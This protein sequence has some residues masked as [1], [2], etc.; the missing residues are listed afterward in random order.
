M[1]TKMN[2]LAGLLILAGTIVNAQSKTSFGLRGGVNF[3]NITGK[4][5]DGDKLDGKL[6]T[7][8]NLGVNAEIPIGIDFYIQ[9]GVLYTSKGANDAFGTVNKVTVSYIEVPVNLLY[10]PELGSGKIILGFGP[11]VAFGVGGRYKYDN[12]SDDLTVKFKNNI[13]AAELIAGDHVYFKGLDAGANFLFGY[14]WI[15]RFSVQLN[16]GLGLVKI[17][18]TLENENPGKTSWKNTG[19]GL[20]LGYRLA[21]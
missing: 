9:P 19:F 6:K 7:G 20:S 13:T 15:N 8:F 12:G 11:Y 2:L 17:N 1:K 5:S 3:Y 21:K 14:E 4:E 16:A 18:P 10:K